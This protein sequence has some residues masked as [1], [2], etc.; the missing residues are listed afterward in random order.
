VQ[1]FTVLALSSLLAVFVVGAC[2]TGDGTPVED[3]PALELTGV[4]A[5]GS[6]VF[7]NSCAGCHGA[8]GDSGSAADLS[9][10]V[11]ELSDNDIAW[12]IADGKG[13]MPAINIEDQA[14]ADV[15]SF[16]RDTHGN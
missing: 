16:L 5:T 13:N 11:P 1:K 9:E 7:A 6:D 3:H 15:I 4:S 8:D 2:A 10:K 12:T 14:I